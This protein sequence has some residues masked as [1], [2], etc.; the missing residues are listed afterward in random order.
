MTDSF[1][2][3]F[4]TITDFDATADHFVFPVQV[5]AVD[6]A[7]THGA[8][9]TV[10]FDDD[11]VATIIAAKLGANHAVLFTPDSGAHK[12]DIFLIVDGNGVAGYQS[13]LDY[14]IQLQNPAHMGSFGLGDF[15]VPVV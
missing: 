5:T 2:A 8:L 6:T 7:I 11:L 1:S 9:G 10:T 4:D 3:A 13:G 15:G 14:V 12:G